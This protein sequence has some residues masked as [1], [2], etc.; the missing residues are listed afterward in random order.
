MNALELIDHLEGLGVT[1]W[2]EAGQLKFRAPKGVL[3]EDHKSSLR[4]SREAVVALL[5]ATAALPELRPDPANRGQ[6]FP[7]TDVQAAYLSGREEA[8]D[9]GGVSCQ[10]YVELKLETV[11]PH[12]LAQAWDKVITRHEMLRA[13]VH[14]E[15]SQQIAAS[16]APYDMAVQDHR[17]DSMAAFE[18]NVLATRARIGGIR[19]EPQEWPLFNMALSQGPGHDIVHFKIDCLIA[20]FMSVQIMLSD[21]AGYLRQADYDP[22]PIELSFRD[23]VLMEHAQRDGSA[24]RKDRAYWMNRMDSL[25]AGPDLPVLPEGK[26]AKPVFDRHSFH[27]GASDW[28]RFKSVAAAQN[29]TPTAALL[30][31]Y[32]EVMATWSR[33]R[34][35]CLNLTMLSRQNSHPEVNALVGD[36]TAVTLLEVDRRN[37]CSFAEA[38]RVIQQQ[39]WTDLDHRSFNGVEVMRELAKARGQGA[40]LMPVVFTSTVGLQESS[41]SLGEPVFGQSETPQVWI[42][43]QVIERDGGLVLQWDVR[44]HVL[45]DG[46]AEAMFA[47]MSKAITA[48]A[49]DAQLWEGGLDVLPVT[50]TMAQRNA[51]TTAGA[52]PREALLQDG[53]LQQA[54][55]T[56]DAVAVISDGAEVTYGALMSAVDHY[57]VA[58]TGTDFTAGD[59]VAI[60]V[61]KGWRQVAAVLAVLHCGGVYLPLDKSMPA[62]RRDGILQAANVGV[63]LSDQLATG[64][65]GDAR[66]SWPAAVQVLDVTGTTAERGSGQMSVMAAPR[67]PQ[68]PA[69]V[70]YTSGS[71]G[72]PKGV[73]IS[74]LAA[75]NTIDAV[76][77]LLHVQAEDRIFGLANLSFDLSVY[78]IF[79]PLAVGAALVLPQEDRRNDPGHWFDLICAHG[80]TLWNSVPAQLQMLSHVVGEDV[81]QQGFHLRAAMLSGDWIPKPLVDWHLAHLPEVAVYSLGGATEAAIWSIFHPIERQEAGWNSVPYGKPL[82]NQSFHV[83]G[84][85]M[86][87]CPDWVTGELYIGGDGLALA[88]FGDEERTNERFVRHPQ[89]GARLYRTG[90][91][92]R[93]RPGNVIEFLGR[94]DTQVK[95]RGHRIELGEIDAALQTLPGVAASAVI[96]DGEDPISR[97]LVGFVTPEQ[98]QEAQARPELTLS[99]QADT[100]AEAT[101]FASYLDHVNNV[102]RRQFMQCLVQQGGLQAAARW[103]TAAEVIATL[104]VAPSQQGLLRQWLQILVTHGLLQQ[105][106]DIY[107]MPCD[108]DQQGQQLAAARKALTDHATAHQ[109]TDQI[110][111]FVNASAAH[112][113]PLLRG[114]QSANELFYGSGADVLAPPETG[115]TML[116][117][118][119]MQAMSQLIAQEAKDGAV[120]SD[121]QALN[122]LEVG[123]GGGETYAALRQQLPDVAMRYHATDLSRYFVNQI[124]A[125]FAGD[126][127]LRSSVLDINQTM[128]AQ[129][130]TANSY[131]ML[132]ARN[133][134]HNALDIPATLAELSTALRPGGLL[135]VVE[136]TGET[137]WTMA[138]LE[139]L[140]GDLKFED[141]RAGSDRIFLSDDEWC[142]IMAAEAGQAPLC[143]PTSDHPL[144]NSGQRLF[145]LRVKSGAAHLTSDQIRHGLGQQLPAYMVPRRIEV[146]DRMPLTANGKID[147][148]SLLKWLERAEDQ[149]TGA[150]DEPVDALEAR[151]IE[152]WQDVLG[153]EKIGRSDDFFDIG[154]DSLLIS[155]VSSKIHTTFPEAE[156]L[157]FSQIMRQILHQHTVADLAT[158]LRG[159]TPLSE[160]ELSA[161][162]PASPL[163]PLG[164]I[165]TGPE[166]ILVHDL[167]GTMSPYLALNNA[168]SPAVRLSGLAV[169]KVALYLEREPTALIDTVAEEY[170]DLLAAAPPAQLVGYG[171]G[172]VMALAVAAKLGERRVAVPKVTVIGGC[173]ITPE[174]QDELALD[175]AFARFIGSD[176]AACGFAGLEQAID[177]LLQDTGQSGAIPAGTIASLGDDPAA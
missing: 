40:A 87:P 44:R 5:K 98:G 168:L 165:D 116:N 45:P 106:G 143:Y 139:F 13:T 83:L 141:L 118:M 81:P 78:D 156:Q 172:G 76:N 125:R 50:A 103:G 56:P 133:V 119:L 68:D 60:A 28:A 146:L 127:N 140:I 4:A 160:E 47:A 101:Q 72:T 175:F 29:V 95:I 82:P 114:E 154:G 176:P 11:D 41:S 130:I 10:I 34:S 113:M 75:L 73:V 131:D 99:A 163:T 8:Y 108:L 136:T 123:A 97:Q 151:L 31:T 90:D 59:L 39:L 49:G 9:Y 86:H 169:T 164:P 88:Y 92:G 157:L 43:C 12:A 25:P 137:A 110:S 33:K 65:T 145:A 22:A 42:D 6:R 177:R 166:T 24:Y 102:A 51:G 122:V 74:H 161:A 16:V 117:R 36:F 167:G 46:V 21:L 63:V 159:A 64:P 14:P 162:A 20:D 57:A 18:E 80:V 173:G 94:D 138:S 85:D 26:T 105:Q 84:P 112:I 61:D 58:L 52:P 132:I 135:L 148:K 32:G 134:L 55:R 115:E 38:S 93:Y 37:A 153:L 79:G 126:A 96:V 120:Q 2:E 100:S 17:G 171:M 54:Q 170:A 48:L 158:F 69:Y 91:L 124:N 30:S 109:I 53:V 144:N 7:L 77:A 62:Q 70:I 23:Y 67:Q 128:Q 147:R 111:G 142:Q 35:F 104:G 19:F 150:E 89:T 152:V 149:T 15:G 27:L 1:L 121:A 107:D 129:G 71:T 174:V 3:T 66:D 155:Q